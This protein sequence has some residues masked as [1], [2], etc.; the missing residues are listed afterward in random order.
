MFHV[1][2]RQWKTVADFS[3]HLN[4]HD[5]SIC[6]WATGAVVH[7]TWKPTPKTWDGMRTMK[8]IQRYY[9]AQKWTSGP[10][11][12]ICAGAPDPLDDGIFQMTPLNLRGT[13][14]AICNSTTWGIEVVGNYDVGPWSDATEQLVLGAIRELFK[15]RKLVVTK[16]SVRGHR[17]CNSKKT[18]PGR[19]IDMNELRSIL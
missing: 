3:A 17:D 10:H 18:C 2:F 9:V 7:H 15:W 19:F 6:N 12:F 14:A 8:A 16:Q 11:L 1:D 13:H 5:P 4:A